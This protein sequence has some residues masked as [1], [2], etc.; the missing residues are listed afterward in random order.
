[1]KIEVGKKYKT[2]DGRDVRIYA[3]DGFGV[4]CVHGAYF[5][6]AD[7]GE[8]GWIDDS[9]TINGEVVEGQEGFDLELVEAE[10][11]GECVM[12]DKNKKY[13]TRSGL[14][15]KIYEIYDDR[16]AYY[17]HGAFYQNSTW[18]IES[19]G[20]TGTNKDKKLSL[21]EVKEDWEIAK[22]QIE[23]ESIAIINVS[24]GT[25]PVVKIRNTAQGIYA[26][27]YTVNGEII[28]CEHKNIRLA[29]KEEVIE[30]FFGGE[31]E[32]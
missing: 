15:V 11:K 29:T 28:E 25:M 32:N 17:A 24:G 5:D 8:V 13:K 18:F 16:C 2:R 12:V 27:I 9:W 22:E 1:M 3:V 10:E 20:I 21:V 26:I 6:T 31:N 14:D 30:Y 19:W 7:Y 4:H 23:K